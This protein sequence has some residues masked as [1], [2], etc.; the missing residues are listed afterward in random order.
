M[1]EFYGLVLIMAGLNR[2]DAKT[3]KFTHYRHSEND[4]N[5]L[6]FDQ[7]RVIYEDK[8]GVLWVGTGSPF[9]G[10]LKTLI[11]KEG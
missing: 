3:G 9:L 5:S 7:V 8:K 6:S 2:M 10:R 11:K 1:K 4:P